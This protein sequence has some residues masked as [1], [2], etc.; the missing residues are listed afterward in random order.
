MAI[1]WFLSHHPEALAIL[2]WGGGAIPDELP[3]LESPLVAALILTAFIPA[4][5]WIREIDVRLL[6]FFHRLGSIPFGAGRWA[7]Q[8]ENAAFTASPGLLAQI[9]TFIDNSPALPAW[10]AEGIAHE[11]QSRTGRPIVSHATSACS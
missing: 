4:F 8:M 1:S 3:K 11:P 6:R 10:I 7:Q 5:P 2:H 9:R